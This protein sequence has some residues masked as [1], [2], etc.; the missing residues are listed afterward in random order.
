MCTGEIDSHS[1]L[2]FFFENGGTAKFQVKKI[3]T[4]NVFV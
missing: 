2:C 3:N 1:Y 4:E